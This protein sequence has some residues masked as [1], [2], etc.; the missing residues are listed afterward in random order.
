[1]ADSDRQFSSARGAINRRTFVRGVGAAAG[2]LG[3]GAAGIRPTMVRAQGTPAPTAGGTLRIA[4]SDALTKDGMNPTLSQDNFYIVPPQSTMAQR[5][6][7]C[8]EE[9]MGM[10]LKPSTSTS[11]SARCPPRVRNTS[12]AR[13]M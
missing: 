10:G 11:M 5:L 3:L 4:F 8:S 12:V 1:M 6:P 2:A 13:M 9:P 7:L